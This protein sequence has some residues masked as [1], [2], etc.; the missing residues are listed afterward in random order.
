M[1]IQENAFE[2]VV[3]KMTAISLGLKVLTNIVAAASD[4]NASLHTI[5]LSYDIRNV[6]PHSSCIDAGLMWTS[7]SA[8]PL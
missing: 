8:V 7:C 1:F 3:G 4:V 2:N 5:V 6:S